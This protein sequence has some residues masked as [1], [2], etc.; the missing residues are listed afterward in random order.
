[1]VGPPSTF[2]YIASADQ[3][4]LT[5]AAQ[6]L[7]MAAALLVRLFVTQLT[8]LR[9]SQDIAPE[10]YPFFVSSGVDRAICYG[11]FVVPPDLEEG[12]YT[13][14]WWWEFNGGE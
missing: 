3:F 10:D 13:F 5:F 6:P 4:T 8:L 9:L 12:I 14:M 2:F 7:I 1:M 11:T